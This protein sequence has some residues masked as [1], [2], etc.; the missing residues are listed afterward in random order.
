[1]SES[2]RE[3]KRKRYE[4]ISFVCLR[5]AARLLWIWNCSFFSLPFGKLQINGRTKEKRT[6][7]MNMF[8]SHHTT[9]L[10]STFHVTQ[11]ANQTGMCLC[12][13]CLYMIVF[14]L[15]HV[16]H[17]LQFFSRSL[18]F[19]HFES[20]LNSTIC[21]SG[22]FSF[23]Y[24]IWC[25]VWLEECACAFVEMRKK[26]QCRNADFKSFIFSSFINVHEHI[27]ISCSLSHATHPT[28]THPPLNNANNF[29]HF[30]GAK[31]WENVFAFM[32]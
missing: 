1:M 29:G 22:I 19:S 15:G 24:L 10:Y 21:P 17:S 32:K 5:V 7:R 28:S 26:S 16:F 6:E 8:P 9:P 4:R 23:F 11:C 18:S 27:Q 13:K 14:R 3:R 31:K 25:Q 2:A 12:I 20:N 30:S